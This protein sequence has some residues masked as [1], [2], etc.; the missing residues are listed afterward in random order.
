MIWKNNTTNSHEKM[1][2]ICCQLTI[3]INFIIHVIKVSAIKL[4]Y[5]AVTHQ[6]TNYVSIIHTSASKLT[7]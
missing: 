6:G 4:K 3:I 2:P 7:I 5:N 1:I